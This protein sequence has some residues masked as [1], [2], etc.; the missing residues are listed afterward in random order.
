MQ[1]SFVLSFVAFLASATALVLS[2]NAVDSSLSK[3][4][5]PCAL[6]CEPLAT[7]NQQCSGDTTCL[8]GGPV[9]ALMYTCSTC[10]YQYDTT[11]YAALQQALDQYVANCATVNSPV[12]ALPIPYCSATAAR[13]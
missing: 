11:K 12:G 10:T 4:Q 9:A 3:R 6:Y 13:A 5:D 2:N 7:A 1:L 8:C